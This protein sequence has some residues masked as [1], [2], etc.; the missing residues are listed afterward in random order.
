MKVWKDKVIDNLIEWESL[1]SIIRAIRRI[2]V[3]LIYQGQRY[4]LIKID[5]QY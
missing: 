1:D 2:S 5:G 3:I 4:G